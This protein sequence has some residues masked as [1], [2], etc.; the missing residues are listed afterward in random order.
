[1]ETRTRRGD[2]DEARLEARARRP[3][4]RRERRAVP[5]APPRARAPGAARGRS[6]RATDRASSP[7]SGCWPPDRPQRCATAGSSSSGSPAGCAS[8]RTARSPTSTRSA[9]ISTDSRAGSATAVAPASRARGAHCSTTTRATPVRSGPRIWRS[10]ASTPESRA[11]NASPCRILRWR[12]NPRALVTMPAGRRDPP[13]DRPPQRKRERRALRGLPHI[14]PRTARRLRR[15]AR[16][17]DTRALRGRAGRHG[18]LRRVGRGS[19]AGR[20]S[21]GARQRIRARSRGGRRGASASAAPT[22][23]CSTAIPRATC[24]T[25][26]SARASST[27]SKRCYADP[28]VVGITTVYDTDQDTLVSRD[29]SETLVIV[30]LARRQRREAAA[31]SSA[32]SRCCARS[33]DPSDVSVGGI[34]AFTLLVQQVARED[35]AQGGDDRAA[36][37]AAARAA[38]SSA[39][40]VAALLPVADRRLRTR[41]L[42]GADPLRFELHRDLGVRDERRRLPRVSASRSTTRCCW[43]SA[44]ARSSQ[45][46]EDVA[47]AVAATLDTA[48]RAVWISGLTVV[49]SLAAL[50]LVP[51]PV[52]RSVSIGGVL[53]IASAIFGALLLLPALLGA[54]GTQVNRWPVGPPHDERAPSVFWH[55]VGNLSMRHP[56][57]SMLGSIC[58]AGAGSRV[59][60]CACAARCRT[61]AASRA[62]S[63]VRR[64]DEALSD[65]SRF[66]PGGASAIPMIVAMPGLAARSGESARAAPL[67][68]AASRPCPASSACAAPSRRSIP[69]R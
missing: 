2:R 20:W 36:D 62:D 29:G 64:V 15:D 31:P 24:A 23:W 9:A 67:R 19:P 51:L 28:G 58:R 5:A 38:S 10:S 30:S 26:A 33:R 13:P 22:C 61:R 34:V 50:M 25:P 46:G 47:D 8:S 7:R 39:G 17:A 65:P 59:P 44:S 16:E 27:A 66:D 55:R 69:T 49:V 37:R 57:A 41:R 14:A 18:L 40:F 1:M 48:G 52:L 6:H 56:V 43:C 12:E 32:S 45:R 60:C 54:L 11:G 35:A 53:V 3:A 42:R 4:R 63:E 21:R 68:D